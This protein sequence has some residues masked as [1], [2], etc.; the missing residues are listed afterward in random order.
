MAEGIHGNEGAG[1]ELCFS[2]P[3]GAEHDVADG[4]REN[5]LRSDLNDTGPIG[6]QAASSIPK[7]RSCVKTIQPLSG[8]SCGRQRHFDLFDAPRG[9]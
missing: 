1:L 3:N 6:P 7:S 4:G 9:I 2:G 5:V 8:I